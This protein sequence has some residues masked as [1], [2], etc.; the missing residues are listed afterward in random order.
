MLLAEAG[1]VFMGFILY[2]SEVQGQT[3]SICAL[4]GSSVELPCSAEKPTSSIKWYT[5]HWEGSKLVQKE[6]ATDGNRVTYNTSEENHPTLTINDLRESDA[7]FYCCRTNPGER[8]P[9]WHTRIQLHVADLQVKVI[10]STEGHTVTLMCSTS[11]PLTENPAAYIWY[12]NREFLYQDWS[13]WYQ[14]LV[15]S[16]EAVRYSCAIKGYEDLRA[17]EVSVDSVTST[18]FNVTY[19][20]GRMCLYKQKPM[21]E[22]CSV[23]YPREV[24]VQKTFVH[25]SLQATCHTSCPLIDTQTAYRWYKGGHLYTE[26]QQFFMSSSS[27]ESL[28]CGV[29]GL[30]DLLSAEVCVEDK[31]CWSV[32]YVRRRICALK[33]STVNISSQYS[34]PNYQQPKS[35]SWYKIKTSGEVVWEQTKAAG[36]VQYHDNMKN[37]HILT[38]NNLKKNDSGEYIFRLQQQTAG[39]KLSGPPGV[40][41]VVTGLKVMFTPSAVVAEGQRVT[42]TCSTSCPLTDNINYIWNLD[43]RPLTLPE[44]QNKNLVLDPVSSQHAGSYTCA[45]KTGTRNII[46]S[47]KTLTVQNITGKQTLAATA[48]AGAVLLVI[49]LLTVFL[50]IRRKRTSGQSPKTEAT[51]TTEQLSP[52]PFDESV[53]AEPAEEELHYG[54]VHF[55]KTQTDALYSNAQPHQSTEQEHVAYA[56]VNFRSNTSLE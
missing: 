22:P 5:E 21:D 27:F 48:G 32:N 17:P 41:L 16:E 25:S 28:S 37:P 23:T 11:C 12:K 15:S 56:V 20:K 36:H 42:L 54:T 35:K 13:P 30:E 4:K 44:N 26:R 40:T 29:K 52:A 53:P 51:D 43:S 34:H 33:G 8:D 31:N 14:H 45:V 38:L 2:I 3:N 9:C 24:H 10:P 46:S 7:T 47:E 49:I 6:I 50:W 19:A 39:W 1:C 55:S 18:C